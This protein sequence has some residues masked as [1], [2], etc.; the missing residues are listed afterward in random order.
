[1]KISTWNEL[2]IYFN[3]CL[4]WVW[5]S[6]ST[7]FALTSR[8]KWFFLIPSLLL[9]SNC[10]MF[11]WHWLLP[12]QTKHALVGDSL[13]P[14]REDLWEEVWGSALLPGLTW[15]RDWRW[16]AFTLSLPK[17]AGQSKKLTFWI[18]SGVLTGESVLF[19]GSCPRLKAGATLVPSCSD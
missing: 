13:C 12:S 1:M 10:Q 17:P 19:Q 18:K 16:L 6:S 7:T 4:W 3:S 8:F 9:S 2:L 15:Q 11:P 14:G 5:Y